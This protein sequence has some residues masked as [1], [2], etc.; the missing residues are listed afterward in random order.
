MVPK[1]LSFPDETFFNL[2]VSNHS[3]D[4]FFIASYDNVI[5]D[6]QT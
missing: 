3:T 2:V 6:R 4:D 5:I 1:I